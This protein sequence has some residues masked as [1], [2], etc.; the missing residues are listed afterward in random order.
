MSV[1][2]I[3]TSV[4]QVCGV[5]AAD[6]SFDAEIMMHI[7]A[8]F[9]VLTQLGVGPEVGF[10]I[11]DASVT[12]DDFVPDA[13]I[14]GAIRSYISQKTKLVFDPPSAG[15]LVDLMVKSCTELEWRIALHGEESLRSG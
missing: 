12:W 5:D 11:A 1:E 4:K 2:S 15:Y 10:S 6:T 7:N 9:S 13:R 8:A 14:I 3:L